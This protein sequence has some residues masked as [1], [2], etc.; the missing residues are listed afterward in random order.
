[1]KPVIKTSHSLVDEIEGTVERITFYNEENG[2]TVAKLIQPGSKQE[3]TI[4]G[5]LQALN[6]GEYIKLGGTWKNHPQFGKQFE[7]HHYSLHLPAT[8]EGIKRYL[9]SGLIKGV[10]PATA[11]RI[12]D[13][14][15]D[16]SL[17]VIEKTPLR[18]LEIPK[19]G[20]KKATLIA[21]AWEEQKHIKEVMLFLQ[22]HEVS[23]NLAIKIYKQ[24]GNDSIKITREN[25]YQLAKDI[26]G[27]GF[28]TADKI[29]RHLGLDPNAPTRIQAG[30]LFGLGKI[31][32]EG[33]CYSPMDYLIQQTVTLLECEQGLVKEQL[34]L[35][36]S[37]QEIHQ[38]KNDVYLPP[39]Y[40]AEQGVA[41]KIIRLQN[42][43]SDRFT[44]FHRIDWS[45]IQNWLNQHSPILL[46]SQQL[47][48]I[49]MAFAN[50]VSIITGGPGTGK[51]TITGNIIQLLKENNCSVLLAAPTGRAAKRLSETT[52]IEAKTI[53]R[54]LEYSPGE[55]GHFQRDQKNPLNADLI[56]IDE[57]SMVDILLMN[58]LLSAI[59]LGSHVLLIG[60]KDQLPSVGPGNVLNDLISSAIIPVTRLDTIFRQAADSF[61]ILNAHRINHGEM[62]IFSKD[63]KDFFLFPEEE[64]I[65]AA[66]WGFGY[67][68]KSN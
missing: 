29:A 34:T 46:T 57:A 17:D 33:H 11:A 61:I 36:I 31:S 13:F 38:E 2:Y 30:L 37:Q 27:I 51:S 22:S 54:L 67:R 7:V 62:P 47:E 68:F 63:S 19:I 14:F 39:F 16:Q 18:L 15:G 42:T 6:I 55:I 43:T 66:E 28:K 9:G 4:V 64:P 40:F 65:K 53:H 41:N 52:G 44:F 5:N 24:Y 20:Q 23:A 59:E 49:Q 32:D 10:G 3:T 48:A 56:I 21:N 60:D 1:M 12:V 26:Y 35:L 45:E 8:V 50:K 25:P 58:H